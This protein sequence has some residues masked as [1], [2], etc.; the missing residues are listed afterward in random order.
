MVTPALDSAKKPYADQAKQPLAGLLQNKKPA[1]AVSEYDRM[2][3]N[4]FDDDLQT[5][6]KDKLISTTNLASSVQESTDEMMGQYQQAYGELSENPNKNAASSINDTNLQSSSQCL[7]FLQSQVEPIST[8]Y[9]TTTSSEYNRMLFKTFDDDLQTKP[10]DK[11]ISTTN[12][13]TSSSSEE[14]D[15]MLMF[16]V[17]EDEKESEGAGFL[18]SSN[19]SQ[20]TSQQVVSYT[21]FYAGILWMTLSFLT[22]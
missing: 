2:H 7:P 17:F 8:D 18:P 9:N 4:T 21:S 3:F 15:H 1:H 6:P 19:V 16:K 12:H 5:K 22:P 13:T 11:I 14:D 20:T 10:N